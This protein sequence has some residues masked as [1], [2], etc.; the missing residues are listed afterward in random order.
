MGRNQ[1]HWPESFRELHHVGLGRIDVS[2]RHV[3][4]G[5]AH[6]CGRNLRSICQHLAGS[7]W[8]PHSECRWGSVTNTA[9]AGG[10]FVFIN[11]GTNVSQW[12][13]IRWSGIGEDLAFRLDGLA[14][15][16]PPSPCVRT[17]SFDDK[18][19][20]RLCFIDRRGT[21]PTI[22][23]PSGDWITPVTGPGSNTAC[24][25]SAPEAIAR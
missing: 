7:E 24:R 10:E 3:Q 4:Y 18:P 20:D 5:W 23:T 1:G 8:R 19:P 14:P 15:A 13:T 12:T 6:P 16:V 17:R 21:I 11:N 22:P 9:Y 2:A 25:W